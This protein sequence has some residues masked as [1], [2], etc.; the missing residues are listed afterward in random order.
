M[1]NTVLAK[2]AVQISANSAQFQAQMAK[3]NKSLL[4][5]ASVAKTVNASLAAFGIGL[6]G[7]Q[8]ARVISG[9]VRSLADFEHSLQKVRAITKATGS[10][11][12]DLKKNALELGRVTK[13]T[14]GQVAELQ[15]VYGRLGFSTKEILA[16]TKATIGLATATDEDLAAAA[17][18][19]GST[20]RAFGLDA[21]ETQ[22]VVDVMAR[23]FTSTALELE[24]F[25]NAMRYVAPD[26]A[27]ANITLEQ[28]TAILGVLADAGIRGS[29][30]GT[31]FRRIISEISKDGRVLSERLKELSN[32]GIG[33]SEAFDEVGQR[34]Q[35]ALL[36]ITKNIDKTDRLT[37]SYN[38]A[39]GAQAEMARIIQDDLTGDVILLS[40][41]YD[42]LIQTI[43][44]TK[45]LRSSVQFLTDLI[46]DISGANKGINA[47]EG[48]AQALQARDAGAIGIYRKELEKLR[49]TG[50]Q[51]VVE[52]GDLIRLTEDWANPQIYQAVIRELEKIIKIT[53]RATGSANIPAPGQSGGGFDF[54]QWL[55]SLG[56][57][58]SEARLSLLA[59][60]GEQL[61]E[62]QKKQRSAFDPQIVAEYGRQ[63]ENL[64]AKISRFTEGTL[65]QNRN[66][67]ISSV[68]PTISQEQLETLTGYTETMRQLSFVIKE[69]PKPVYDLEE[70]LKKLNL[71]MI[72]MAPLIA[73]AVSSL[74]EGFGRALVGAQSFGS[75]ILQTVAGFAKQLGEILIAA[76]IAVIAAKKSLLAN[77]GLAIAAG[78]ALVAIASAV[79]A[80]IGSAHS[81]TF[82]GGGGGRS[83]RSDS[84]G[85]L[86][87]NAPIRVEGKVE[88]RGQDLFVILSNYQKNNRATSSSHG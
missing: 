71:V 29:R 40:S 58:D 63:I 44:K 36:V 50:S 26:A 53:G 12:E 55:S 78:V 33:I 37:E 21:S 42:G 81:K 75:A 8:I 11:F 34:A 70:T 20:V 4:S 1:A 31:S 6:G 62:L 88:L 30:A 79:S 72:D 45:T 41:A 82:G 65:L 43:G 19:A 39:A 69:L 57:S 16:A 86:A 18:V 84:L 3:A 35:T 56:A 46:N 10:Q 32:R 77:P 17:D 47:L 7:Y 76:G 2:M 73:N 67:Q 15:V 80:S 74:A 59:S 52:Y 51:L 60:L 24:S 61:E 28:T 22:R 54:F 5:V 9:A 13:F 14:A 68:I 83:S 85:G 27:A 87:Q 66:P 64:Q 23:S 49:D 48:F 25:R 38:N